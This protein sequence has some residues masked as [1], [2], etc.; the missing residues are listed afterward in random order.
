MTS[1]SNTINS[2]FLRRLQGLNPASKGSNPV[3]SALSGGSVSISDTLRFGART[4]ASSVQRLNVA[5]GGINVAQSG[6][7]GLRGLVNEMIDIADKAALSSTGSG[8]RRRLN[9]RFQ[10]LG[11]DFVNIIDELNGQEFEYLTKEGLKDVLLQAG[12][13]PDESD[14]I[15]ELFAQFVGEGTEGLLVSD[16]IQ[17]EGSVRFRPASTGDSAPQQ[18]SAGVGV[19]STKVTAVG[20]AFAAV[21]DANFKGNN[22]GNV[23]VITSGFEGTVRTLNE[24]LSSDVALVGASPSGFLAV[25]SQQ[26]FEG[27]NSSGVAQ[28]F[29]VDS[30]LSVVGQVTNITD[31]N[32]SVE[33]AAVSDDGLTVVTR[34]LD[35]GSGISS[36]V[37]YERGEIGQDPQLTSRT[38]LATGISASSFEPV[39]SRSGDYVAYANNSGGA[40]FLDVAS[41]TAN[42]FLSSQSDVSSVSFTNSTELAVL[43]SD[44]GG[45]FEVGVVGYDSSAYDRVLATGLLSVSSSSFATLEDSSG[46]NGYV[47]FLNNSGQVE[48]MDGMGSP[49]A[50]FDFSG[51]TISDLSLAPRGSSSQV[52]VGSVAQFP[53]DAQEQSYV[54]RQGTKESSSLPK[55]QSLFDGEANIL[56][57]RAAVSVRA[58]L[59]AI[60]DRIDANLNALENA[61]NVIGDNLDLVRASGFAF[62][63]ISNSISSETEADEV[64]TL[65]AR[66]IRENAVG[67]LDQAENLELMVVAA[68]TSDGSLG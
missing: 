35:S 23:S 53:G 33:S 54:A 39:I 17:P 66:R 1:I 36:I 19:S 37:L 52:V 6:L 34:E 8:T 46:G 64:A 44:G 59:E 57:R 27:F 65:L 43:K 3:K 62:L 30:S 2:S 4:F 50:E 21:D 28:L 14:G 61:R 26:D 9:S 16:E 7:A 55:F 5:I 51:A 12:L 60:G 41:K 20:A 67:V 58:N 48:V 22:S 25:S 32:V 29:L 15:A 42:T 18:I 31:P 56:S 68:L 24:T 40:E 11:E 45:G 13:D 49:L 63:D 47:A 38:V 10:Q